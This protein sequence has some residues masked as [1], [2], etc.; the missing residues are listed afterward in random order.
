MNLRPGADA[1]MTSPMKETA[2]ESGVLLRSI[3]MAALTSF[4]AL[5]PAFAQD[6]T[7]VSP[8]PSAPLTE[9]DLLLVLGTDVSG[10]VSHTEAFLQRKGY[11]DAFRHRDVI[12][13]IESGSLGRI[14]VVYIDWSSRYYNQILIDWTMIEG[15]ETS[16]AY[17]NSL[18]TTPRTRGQGTSISDFFE[19]AMS[20]IEIAP[21]TAPKTV[22]DVSGDG[23][24]RSGAPL[25]EVRDEV[26]SRGIIINGLPIIDPYGWD[27]FPNL[28]EY[29]RGCVIGG[30][31]AFVQVAE[32]FA[33]FSR[34]IRRKLILELSG[35]SPEDLP[36]DLPD[37]L[38]RRDFAP[39]LI[40]S[41][42]PRLIPVQSV[43]LPDAPNIQ[44]FRKDY[45]G[46]CDT[47]DFYR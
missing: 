6:D 26:V 20:V 25:T 2:F 39:E 9:V 11:A 12:T 33:D 10:S 29:F 22:I 13:A 32:G 7:S 41:D 27:E 4:I 31:G 30:P 5:V 28:D 36:E 17:A 16:L 47:W 19:F 40:P 43:P 38:P 15:E 1:A 21:F 35:L 24:N 42:A 37:G 8:A 45:E 44:P 14:G 3:R 34:A 46:A 18:M 23:P